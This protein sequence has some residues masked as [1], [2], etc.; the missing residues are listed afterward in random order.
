MPS[1]YFSLSATHLTIVEGE[2]PLIFDIPFPR[3]PLISLHGLQLFLK[4]IIDSVGAFIL[5][6]LTAPIFV[7]TA[8]L[9]R[10][11]SPGPIFFRQERPGLYQRPFRIWKFRTMAVGSEEK[12]QRLS[13]KERNLFFKPNDDPRVTRIGRFLR[14]YSIDELPQLFNVL[15]GEMSLVGPRPIL[16]LELQRFEEWT[17]MRRF[18]MKPGLTCIWQVSGRSNTSDWTRIRHDLNYVDSWSLWLDFKL[19]VKTIE[20]VLRAK[21]AV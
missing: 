10:L 12:E 8:I 9:I 17:F 6:I 15:R 14:K 2:T 5:L 19:L 1:N 21:G 3:V 11:T 16:D 7:L 20:V 4:A 18:S 13:K